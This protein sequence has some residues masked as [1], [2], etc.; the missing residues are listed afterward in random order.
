MAQKFPFANFQIEGKVVTV[1]MVAE[2]GIATPELAQR[3]MVAFQKKLGRKDLVLVAQGIS[4]TPV[5]IGNRAF[6]DK[7][8]DVPLA[9]INWQ[10]FEA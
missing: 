2:S 10:H 3:S 4:L 5:Y 9:R 7:L 8:K 6:V 1:I